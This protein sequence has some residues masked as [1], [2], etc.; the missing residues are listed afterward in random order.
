MTEAKSR[1]I[2]DS[3]LTSAGWVLKDSD[4]VCNVDFEVTNDA[5]RIDYLLRDSHGFPLCILEAKSELKSPLD[6]KEQA[7]RYARTQN[8]RF[9]ILSNGESHFLWDIKIG[10]PVPIDNFPTQKELEYKDGFCPNTKSLTDEPIDS[11]FV[12]LTQFPLYRNAPN[13]LNDSTKQDFIKENKLRFLRPYQIKALKNI[14]NAVSNGGSRFLLEMATGTGKTVTACAIMKMFLRT[15]NVKRV[16]FLV[17]R[18]ELETQAWRQFNEILKNDYS[19]SIWKENTVEWKKSE[20][21]VSTIQTLKTKNKYKRLFSPDDFDLVI[22][23]EAHRSIGGQSRKV[24]EYFIGYKLGLTAT[25]KDY[26][27][28]VDIS[29]LGVKDPRELERRMLLDTYTTFGCESG[30]PTYRYTLIDGVQDG[31][32]V[33]P[34]VFDARTEIT[35][36]L[37]SDKGYIFSAEDESGND[38]EVV[39]THKN[40]EKTFYS[41]TTNRIFCKT[42][43]E[44]AKKDPYTN[45][46]GKTLIFCVSQSHASK[47]TN[48]LNEYAMNFFPGMYNSDFAVQVT[49][50][51]DGAQQMT[52]DFS[53]NN[54]NGISKFNEFYRTSKTR[55]CVTVGMMTTGYDCTDILNI[56]LMRPIFSP[57]DFVQ[58]KGRGTRKHNFIY[59]WI[60]KEDSYEVTQS[61]KQSFFLFDFFGNCEFFESKFD[62][63]QQLNIPIS[64][65]ASSGIPQPKTLVEM[66][67]FLPDPIKSLQITNI[68]SEGMK[69]D[70]MFFDA[71]EREV[72]ESAEISKFVESRDFDAAEQFLVENILD[73]PNN[74]YTLEKLR[75]SLKLDRRLTVKELLMHSF[76]IIDHIK[77]KNELVEEE[78]EK[79]DSRYMPIDSDFNQVKQFFTIYL[80][81]KF[82]REIIES[83]QYA[84]LNTTPNGQ[85]FKMLSEDYRKLIPEYIKDHVQLNRFLQ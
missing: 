42:F 38:E 5:G 53:N 33:N 57:T 19:T 68:S 48:I 61:E 77:T 20:I 13:F 72:R 14:Q 74:F 45:E 29:A 2:I 79:F 84:Q 23:D 22:S 12:V 78:F 60:S 73:K 56:C 9:V 35:T 71:F 59:D 69:I 1:I 32:L 7:R 51:V 43:F 44:N 54:L 85:V 8:C 40:F 47:I 27:K 36:K 18:I 81:D 80:T 6:G 16:L 28:S 62:Y 10:N 50:N 21:V 63:D 15:S 65:D 66:E 52:I 26:L 25:P 37:L 11:D 30:I 58:M 55:V 49:S 31:Y 75:K 70:R 67:N 34:K 17:D 3:L 76:K 39:F 83:K 46:V 41:E 4:G 64:I 24:F 82:V